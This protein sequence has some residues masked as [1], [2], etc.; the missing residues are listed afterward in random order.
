M[1]ENESFAT[2][3][4]ASCG[5]GAAF[6]RCNAGFHPA[7]PASM[8][9]NAVCIRLFDPPLAR[10]L[11]SSRTGQRDLAEA[12]ILAAVGCAPA[13]CEAMTEI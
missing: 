1:R 3:A 12:L 4:K 11:P 5:V 6:C 9:G 8:Q 7:I 13:G 2:P 10:F